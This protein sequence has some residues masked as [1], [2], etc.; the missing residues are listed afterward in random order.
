LPGVTRRG[1]LLYALHCVV[2]FAQVVASESGISG[3]GPFAPL[4][5]GVF[6]REPELSSQGLYRFF[7]DA[8]AGQAYSIAVSFDLINWNILTNV[9]GGGEALWVEDWEA[10]KFQRRFYQVGTSTK[11]LPTPITNMIFIGPGT[12]TMGSP[13][14]EDGAN[15]NERPQT[16]VT[17]SREFWIG[18]YE[19]NQRDYVELVGS[20]NS[21]H[22]DPRLPVDFA[23]WSQATNFC[24]K[25]TERERA[26]GRLPVGF[27][28]RLP[29][30]AEWE[31]ACRAGS[32]S[33][34]AL[35]V[36]T[37]LSSTQANFDGTFPYGGAVPGPNLGTTT[38]GGTYGP[39]AW[40]IYD[41]HGNVGEWCQDFYGPYPG[42]AITDP[43]GPATGFTRVFRGG[44]YRSVGKNCR[45]SK[46]EGLS[47]TLRN[48]AQGFRVVL[49]VD[50]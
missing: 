24:Q 39:N 12:F 30:E 41:M 42:G 4:D 16:V 19:V 46:R 48:F 5:E 1:I 17:L 22:E 6:L 27:V 47:P 50:P 34:V 35:G 23:N 36:G 10:W 38:V 44:G 2:I 14:T 40:G 29:Y 9:Q 32:T 18:K 45:S 25:L 13:A 31:Y 8:K 37:S 11:V 49:A 20:N 28:Y 21:N 43:K 33:A 3:R 26:Q 7:F 15:P